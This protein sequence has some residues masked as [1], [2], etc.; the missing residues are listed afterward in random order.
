MGYQRRLGARHRLY[1]ERIAGGLAGQRADR[2]VLPVRYWH[3]AD[4][5]ADAQHVRS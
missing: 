2:R 4:I 5:D 3:L 1:K